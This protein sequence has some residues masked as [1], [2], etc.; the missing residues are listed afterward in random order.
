[1]SRTDSETMSKLDAYVDAPQQLLRVTRSDLDRLPHDE[2]ETFRLKAARGLLA[3]QVERI[4][5]VRDKLGD[6]RPEDIA[7]LNQLVGLLLRPD[8]YKTYDE[9]WL[10]ENNFAALTLWMGRF[11]AHDYSGV[12]VSDVTSVTDWCRALKAQTGDHICH[13]SG[14]SGV[15]GFLPR[16]ER[17]G[18][19]QADSMLWHYQPFGGELRYHPG[20][21]NDVVFA[22]PQPRQ[23]FRPPTVLADN[24]EQRYAMTVLMLPVYFGPEHFIA[25]G[26]VRTAQRRGTLDQLDDPIAATHWDEVKAYQDSLPALLEAW[27]D[28]LLKHEGREV[29]VQMTSDMAWRLT[30]IL[31]ARGVKGAFAPGSV[32]SIGGGVKDGSSMPDDWR[33]QLCEAFGADEGS[34]CSM[35]GMSE[36]IVQVR[37][38]SGGMYHATPF[39][40]PFVLDPETNEPLPRTGVQTGR[41]AVLELLSQDN[42][43]GLITDDRATIHWDAPCA[44]GATGPLIDPKS[45][46]RL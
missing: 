2:I 22:V 19:S 38:C 35:Y 46:G 40:I 44:C 20:E 23:Q 7:E 26:K 33:D 11:T 41:F 29:I 9:S 14:T 13:S 34:F 37:E 3:R 25:Q 30:Q 12:D 15:V 36:A 4:P 45:I 32:Y 43:G 24:I 42:W 18:R 39:I 31:Q 27:S 17:D 10:H 6:K 28:E 16:S 1:M 8:E 21:T 5:V